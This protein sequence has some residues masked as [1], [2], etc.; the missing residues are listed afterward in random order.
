M[1][2]M[3]S[4]TEHRPPPGGER[5]MVPIVGAPAPVRGA[6]DLPETTPV[7]DRKRASLQG[8]AAFCRGGR[9]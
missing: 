6:V 1:V 4:P 2:G 7:P 8:P 5:A 9:G 3:T